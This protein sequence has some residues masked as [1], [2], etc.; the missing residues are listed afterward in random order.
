M[1]NIVNSMSFLSDAEII[2]EESRFSL[3]RGHWHRVVRKSQEATELAIKGL[4]KYLGLDYPKSHILGKVIKKELA[5]HRLFD[6]EEL[7]KIAF[8]SDSLAFDR[9]PSFY[10]SFDG[11]SA[12]SLFDEDDAEEAL[13]NS[14]WVIGKIKSVIS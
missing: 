6:K 9:E 13:K 4:F 7:N 1:N 12:L 10:G 5:K 14:E 8:I 3:E 11:I 2:L